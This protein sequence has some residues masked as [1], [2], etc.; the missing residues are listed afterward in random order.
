MGQGGLVARTTRGA[1]GLQRQR[2]A[3]A[4]QLQPASWALEDLTCQEFSR[5]LRRHDG[6]AC[7]AWAILERVEGGSRKTEREG[8]CMLVREKNPPGHAP[9]GSRRFGMLRYRAGC[10][11]VPD[12][13]LLRGQHGSSTAIS[14]SARAPGESARLSPGPPPSASPTQPPAGRRLGHPGR[15]HSGPGPG[16]GRDGKCTDWDRAGS[17][18]RGVQAHGPSSR[19]A[20]AGSCGPACSCGPSP[21]GHGAERHAKRR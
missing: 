7:A 12:R 9:G 21:T 20:S 16:R 14:E 4:L 5:Q 8:E 17:G 2:I 6:F 1:R 19:P 18:A 3:T 11:P 10:A 15:T 13:H